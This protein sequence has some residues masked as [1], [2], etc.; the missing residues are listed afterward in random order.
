MR[1]SSEGGAY[2]GSLNSAYRGWA[3]A[4]VAPVTPARDRREVH[5]LHPIPLHRLTDPDVPRRRTT[6]DGRPLLQ[7]P[8]RRGMVVHPPTGALLWRFREVALLGR[9][10]RVAGLAQ[11]VFTRT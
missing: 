8:L 10:T 2:N 11:S 7:L 9:P 3:I 6:D 5:S 4:C 1:C